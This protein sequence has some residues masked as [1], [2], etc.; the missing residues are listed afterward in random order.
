MISRVVADEH[1]T[2][3]ALAE[4][5]ASRYGVPLERASKE[6]LIAELAALPLD[7]RF[8]RAKA[9]LFFT[10]RK[11]PF[12]STCRCPAGAAYRCC[13]YY[14]IQSVSGCPFDCSYCILQHYL[15][16]NP[17][18]SVFVNRGAVEHEMAA[19]LSR[20][21]FLRVGTG[22]LADSLALDEVLDESGFFAEVI[23]RNGWEKRVVFELK[24]KS[25]QVEN[26]LA[27]KRRFPAADLVLGLSVNIAQF[28]ASEERGTAPMTARI[29]AAERFLKAGGRVALHFDPLVMHE[30]YLADYRALARRLFER[31]DPRQAAWVSLGGLRYPVPMRRLIRERWPDSVLHI[32]EMFP[33]PDHKM[34]YFAPL[35]RRFYR[36]MTA[37]L[38]TLAPETPCY[39]CMEPPWMWR[40]LACV[41]PS[42]STV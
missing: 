20:H 35:R 1:L 11:G 13:G 8:R 25:A 33:A 17:F 21:P 40:G 9:T 2:D 26:L 39:L 34:R 6:A 23:V 28:H 42:G 3:R 16:N 41:L 29:A 14:T 22:E 4:E 31:I 12:L 5:A 36:E 24:T 15:A 38:R 37:L 7:E 27:A 32:G 30:E 19:Y 10:V 18:I